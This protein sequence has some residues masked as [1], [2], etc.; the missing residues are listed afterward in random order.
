MKLKLIFTAAAFGLLSA[1]LWADVSASTRTASPDAP[2]EM[3][4]PGRYTA[5]IMPGIN[6]GMAMK[7]EQ[8]LGKIQGV[9]KVKALSS[10]SSIHFTIKDG[11][12]VPITNVQNAV[13]GTDSDAV[14]S[15]PILEHSLAPS[16]GL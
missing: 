15:A 6:D 9:E 12:K 13:T 8:S 10:D 4:S 3:I 5:S 1:P 16:P 7:L 14:M 11:A 2:V